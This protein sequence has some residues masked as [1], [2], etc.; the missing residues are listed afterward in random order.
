MP[1]RPDPSLLRGD[2]VRV[3]REYL[4]IT[5]GDLAALLDVSF[6]T[7]RSWEG[8]R[9]GTPPGVIT[10]LQQLQ[11]SLDD[12]A[13]AAIQQYESLPMTGQGP[14]FTITDEGPRP[15]GWQR[16]I[17]ARVAQHCRDLIVDDQAKR[18]AVGAGRG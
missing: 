1:A 12:E 13:E 9:R 4:G 16:H 11:D 17:A 5:R 15:A 8:N 3:V 6:D 18:E 7:V 10:Q 14:V 2:F